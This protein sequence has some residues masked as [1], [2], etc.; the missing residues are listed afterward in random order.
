[1]TDCIYVLPEHVRRAL[2]EKYRN[3]TDPTDKRIAYMVQNKVHLTKDEYDYAMRH[4]DVM[5]PQN[6]AEPWYVTNGYCG[7]NLLFWRENNCGYTTDFKDARKWS[8]EEAKQQVRS[9]GK[10]FAAWP[11]HALM[12]G[13]RQVVESQLLNHGN[14]Y[15]GRK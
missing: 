2:W 4:Y 11:E 13:L 9:S 14:S 3:T 10:L 15:T 6:G 12:R 5:E 1:M 8:E 7:N